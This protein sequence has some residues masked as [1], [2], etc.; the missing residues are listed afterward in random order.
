MDFFSR[1]DAYSFPE[2]Q[3]FQKRHQINPNTA[4]WIFFPEMTLAQFSKFDN[5][6]N[7]FFTPN[8]P[9]KPFL[10]IFS[11]NDAPR[12][13]QKRLDFFSKN[14]ASSVPG[15]SGVITFIT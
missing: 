4:K 11:R 9:K 10:D 3:I 15:F 5:F 6:E 7:L 1:N 12:R 8:Y 14:D 2:N 13:S